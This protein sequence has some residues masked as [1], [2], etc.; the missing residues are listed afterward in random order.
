MQFAV[1]CIAGAEGIVRDALTA[2]LRNVRI[3][4]CAVG[5]IVL[6][7][8]SRPERI[9]SL[10]YINN[11][12]V[13]LASQPL[14]G[15]A[16][17]ISKVVTLFSRTELPRHIKTVSGISIKYSRHNR[18]ERLDPRLRQRL[19]AHLTDTFRVKST[20]TGTSA[21]EFWL[22]QRS[23]NMVYLLQR[24][25]V[26]STPDT[27]RKPKPHRG[28]LTPELAAV[29]CRVAQIKQGMSLCDPFAGYGGIVKSMLQ[30][31]PSMIHSFDKDAECLEALRQL[32]RSASKVGAELTVTS[33]DV[34]DEKRLPT[35][36]RI[37]T[38]PPWGIYDNAVDTR[39]F[40]TQM[41]KLFKDMLAP[42]G[43]AVLLLARDI[44]LDTIARGKYNVS[45]RADI[46]VNGKKATIWEVK[47]EHALDFT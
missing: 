10:P 12:F 20:A 2:D 33:G 37:V 47:V 15:Q 11:A 35:V 18:F 21:T 17:D 27:A 24:L 44:K 32:K 39:D 30:C 45:R 40:Y 23:D 8:G 14:V 28:E 36:D 4:S 31:L 26:Q 29:L 42:D 5:F 41:L 3:I 13:I 6:E 9:S 1:I 46:L 38:D 16:S 43:R 34:F 22:Y 7:T 19:E 25:A